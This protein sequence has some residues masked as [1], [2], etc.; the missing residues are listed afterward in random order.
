MKK[1]N[2]TKTYLPPIKNYVNYLKKVWHTGQVT[3]SGPL[4]TELEEKLK[5]YLGVKHVC[6]VANGTLALQI[7][8]KALELKKEIITTPFSYVATSS[9]IVWQNCSPV[10]ADID[11]ETLNID[12]KK[13]EKCLTKD[14]EAIIATHTFGNPCSIEEI[15]R[16]AK[17]YK[18][19]VIYDAAHAFGVGY[20]GQSILNYGDIS[21]L[22]FHATKIFH[23]IEGGAMVTNDDQLARKFSYMR[24]G[25]HHGPE[26]FLGLGINAKMSE[27]NAAMGLCNLPNVR[28][29]ISKRQKLS[30]IYDQLLIKEIPTLKTQKVLSAKDHNWSYYPLLFP[31]QKMLLNVQKDLNRI[32]IY[33]RRYFYPSLNTLN[34]L[35]KTSCPISE[36]ISS[37]IL[38]LPMGHDVEEKHIHLIGKVIRENL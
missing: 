32:S 21:V 5:K 24:H 35:N 15:A 33:P 38:C 11:P 26:K 19:K 22:S 25:G 30:R 2:V 17:K 27:F 13:I 3:N 1:I 34:F 8:L 28:P 29:V 12:P 9:S 14:T 37:R 20:K 16:I 10:Y 6:A 36:D 31:S 4:V 18:L 23:T 7:T